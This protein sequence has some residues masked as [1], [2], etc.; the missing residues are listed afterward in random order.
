MFFRKILIAVDATPLSAHAADVGIEL[1]RSLGSELA[2]TNVVD[3]SQNWAPDCGIPADELVALAQQ[4]G[5]HLLAEFRSR[6]T[7]GAPPLEFVR[8]GNPAHEIVN[9]AKEWAADVVVIASHAREGVPRLLLGS[10]AEAVMRHAPCAVLV[11][12]AKP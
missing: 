4:D 2:L 5:K 7:L 3:P 10:V 9:V 1:A 6:A 12:R 11:V 8:V